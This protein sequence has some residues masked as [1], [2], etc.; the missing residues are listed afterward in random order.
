MRWDRHTA[1]VARAIDEPALSYRIQ[2]LLTG[3]FCRLGPGS[4]R[5]VRRA[6]AVTPLDERDDAPCRPGAG[7]LSQGSRDIKNLEHEVLH[8]NSSALVRLVA[9]NVRATALEFLKGTAMRQ[10]TAG[11]GGRRFTQPGGS[12]EARAGI[13][14]PPPSHPRRQ[15]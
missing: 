7:A 3:L 15:V 2:W 4:D 6:R 10:G 11:A 13:Y 9:I 5:R 12:H 1:T 14:R 8:R